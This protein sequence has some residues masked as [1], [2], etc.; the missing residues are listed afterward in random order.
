MNA[1]IHTRQATFDTTFYTVENRHKWIVEQE[2]HY[3]ILVAV[4]DAQVV[5]CAFVGPYRSRD[6]YRGIGEFSIYIRENYQGQKIGKKLLESLV[7]ACAEQG[8]WKLVS[9]I[10]DFN[11]ASRALCR[12]CGFREVGV[13]E[14][15]G[16]LDGKWVDCI[17]VEKLIEKNLD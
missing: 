11:H 15:H 17:I 9:R 2:E 13:Y 7:N 5:G 1:G 8:Y 10:F 12:S 16:K 3:P 14:K 6:C 4:L